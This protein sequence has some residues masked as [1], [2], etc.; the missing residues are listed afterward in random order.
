MEPTTIIQLR[1]QLEAIKEFERKNAPHRWRV[2][3]NW[4]E[5]LLGAMMLGRLIL[6][7]PS[8][9]IQWF[10]W[11]LYLTALLLIFHGF[12]MLFRFSFDKRLR[13]ILEAVLASAEKK[14]ELVDV[15]IQRKN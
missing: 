14:S 8:D 9:I 6:S 1:V 12:Y 11:F 5:V 7:P 4:G 10:G 15:N 3:G 13:L 2:F